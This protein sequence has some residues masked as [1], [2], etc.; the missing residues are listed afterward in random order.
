MMDGDMVAAARVGA[1]QQYLV[2]VASF[3]IGYSRMPEAERKD[4]SQTNTGRSQPILH[5]QEN[6]LLPTNDPRFIAAL[7]LP[8]LRAFG[9]PFEVKYGYI[10]VSGA[11]PASAE[12]L[13]GERIMEHH[14][15]LPHVWFVSPGE[16]LPQ[17]ATVS[18]GTEE[19]RPSS[20]GQPGAPAATDVAA[21]SAHAIL[22]DLS[23]LC[24]GAKCP[25]ALGRRVEAHHGTA[26]PND[27]W[28]YVEALPPQSVV[29]GVS[30]NDL[31]SFVNMLVHGTSVE[32]LIDRFPGPLR[33][34]LVDNERQVLEFAR[35][36]M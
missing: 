30:L 16:R 14:T 22:T 7:T 2:N 34:I 26:V 27:Q 21:P 17:G 11:F 31:R 20:D 8:V 28:H 3:C 25:V 4:S 9:I 6:M 32:S 15:V 23:V 1:A 29:L 19:E 35:T 33:S 24:Y 18:R 36:R 10:H 13:G 5:G 12:G